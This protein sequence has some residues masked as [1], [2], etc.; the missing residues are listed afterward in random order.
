MLRKSGIRKIHGPTDTRTPYTD[1]LNK[2]IFWKL[3]KYTDPIFLIHLSLNFDNFLEASSIHRVT[4][5]DPHFQFTI[6]LLKRNNVHS[7][8]SKFYVKSILLNLD[9]QK[10]P[11]H[12]GHFRM[13]KS[14]ITKSLWKGWG[15]MEN[16]LLP[17]IINIMWKL[18]ST[19]TDEIW[20]ISGLQSEPKSTNFNFEQIDFLRSVYVCEM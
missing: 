20:W 2:I 8:N 18:F 5:Q 13:S 9:P 3:E 16:F 19:R 7:K 1:L 17:I 12:F 6:H 11:L 15:K 10:W 14:K 4:D